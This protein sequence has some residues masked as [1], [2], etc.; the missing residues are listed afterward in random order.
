[1]P[2]VPIPIVSPAESAAWDARAEAHGIPLASL[3]ESAGRAAAAVLLDR[4]PHAARQGVLVAAGPGNNGG[5]GWVL[6]RTLHRLGVPVWVAPAEGK[7]TPLHDAAAALARADGVRSVGADGP[8]PSVALLVDALLGTGAS[9]PP[10]GA[11]AAVVER[12]RDLSLPI[13]ALDGPTGL[14]LGSG[15]S[16]GA[17]AAACSVTFGGLRRGHLLARDES[18]DIVVVDIGLPP[19]DP[20]L[21]ELV[22]DDH[23]AQWLPPL[24]ANEHKGSRGRIVIVGGAPGMVGAVR[25]AGRAAFAA[26]AGL[27]H[28]VAPAA[29][30][31]DLASVEPDLQTSEWDDGAPPARTAELLARADAVVVG[32]GLGRGPDAR[33]RVEATLAHSGK[34]PVLLDADALSAFPGGA[35]ILR[36]LLKGRA[37]VLTPHLGEFRSLFPDL[38]S[39]IEH[40]PWAAAGKSADQVGAVVL[41]KGVPSVVGEPGRGARWTVAAGNPGLATGGSGDVLSGLIAAMLARGLDPAVATALGAQALGRAADIAARRVTARAMR[42]MDVVAVLPDLWRAWEI[43]RGARPAPRAPVLVE[44]ER[45][46]SV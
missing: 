26:G 16:H 5:D 9:G 6:A 35:A 22:D 27:V 36:P 24:A 31:R 25:L 41:V 33:S 46:R 32:P 38:S 23:A 30:L 34:A 15:A 8:W 44:L 3:M 18:G 21:P 14:D 4:F 43:R 2:A 12:L 29:S 45:P 20:A 28:I 37:A 19:A 1:M 40:D 39:G 7:G 13:L 42:P 11:I 10:R 17:P